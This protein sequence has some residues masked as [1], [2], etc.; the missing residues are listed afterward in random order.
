MGFSSKIALPLAGIAALARAATHEMIVGTFGTTSLYTLAFDDEAL[1]LELVANTS[2]PAASS[3]IALSGDKKH[4]YGNSYNAE[5]PTFVGYTLANASSIAYDTA[6][7]AGGECNAKGIFVLA[8]PNPP[9]A[10][11]GNFFSGSATADCG[12]VMSVTDD[13]AL[14]ETIQNFTYASGSGVH[15][16]ALSP[17]SRFLYSADDGGNAIWTHSIDAAT[18]AVAYVSNITGPA[19]GSDP[20]HVAVHP[21]GAYLYVVLEGTSQLAQ[22]TVDA[23]TGVLSYADVIYP[24]LRSNESA[25]DFWADEVALSASASYLWATNRA[26]SDDGRGYISAFD[27]DASGAIVRQNFLLPTTSSGGAANSVAPSPFSDRFVAL[28]DALTGFVEIWEL[29]EDGASASVAAHLDLADAAESASGCCA[30]AVWY[31]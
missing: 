10:V 24:L 2:T 19:E 23:E 15:G 18:G 25:S 29:S 27:L 4:L 5:T 17:D 21:G 11:Y 12:S 1:T 20:R 30:N 31:S 28:T 26:W 9:Y 3:W 16:T 14:G 22:Y 8:D 6:V 13:G 7:A